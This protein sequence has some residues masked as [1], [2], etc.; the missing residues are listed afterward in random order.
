[1]GAA[2]GT[3]R[4][5]PESLPSLPSCKYHCSQWLLSAASHP[6]SLPPLHP[7][8]WLLTL[9]AWP[10]V[11]SSLRGPWLSRSQSVN[12]VSISPRPLPAILEPSAVPGAAC[13]LQGAYLCLFTM[14]SLP[15]PPKVFFVLFFSPN[16]GIIYIKFTNL[17]GTEGLCF[18]CLCQHVATVQIK[19]W[20][21]SSTPKSPLL[22]LT[23]RVTMLVIL[24]PLISFACCS[25]YRSRITQQGLVSGFFPSVCL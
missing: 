1:M 16:G 3:H 14:T 2:P 11:V 6:G 8:L 9:Q 22:P 20:N 5:Y 10:A 24:S 7:D 4:C 21:P 12:F 15:M 18:P 19:V 17:A 25:L 23:P 13:W